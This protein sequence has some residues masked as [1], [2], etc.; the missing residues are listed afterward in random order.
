MARETN[1]AKAGALGAAAGALIALLTFYGQHRTPAPGHRP[2][3][4]SSRGPS[5][6]PAAPRARSTKPAELPPGCQR[7]ETAIATWH[8]TAGTAW[9]SERN[10][11]QRAVSELVMATQASA[12]GSGASGTVYSDLVALNNDFSNLYS[13]A[14]TRA[15]SAYG[16]AAAQAGTDARVLR[17]DC[18][19]G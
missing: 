6:A 11:A 19:T 18:G 15:G 9:D 16:Q 1:W 17:G 10:A 4:V 2:V 5:P 7:A 3:P 8:A 14:M 12:S 13:A